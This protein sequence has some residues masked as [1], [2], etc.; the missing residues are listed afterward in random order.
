MAQDQENSSFLKA[1]LRVLATRL[2]LFSLELTDEKQNLAHVVVL[3]V[4]MSML[5]ILFMLSF[6][7]LFLALLWDTP[8][9]YWFI[10]ICILTFGGCAL[11]AFIKLKGLL[12]GR[13]PFEITIEELKADANA[14]TKRSNNN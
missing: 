5:L 3:T 4:A 10:V 1:L 9:I 12:F 2:E 14:I 8:Y 13:K 7:S 11:G 6:M